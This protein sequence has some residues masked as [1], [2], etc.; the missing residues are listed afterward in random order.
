MLARCVLWPCVCP[1]VCLSVTSW[2]SI[3]MAGR[4]ELG[5]FCTESALYFLYR[6]YCVIRNS[7]FCKKDRLRLLLNSLWNLVQ[8]YEL[9]SFYRT[10]WTAESSDCAPSVCEFFLFVYEISQEP[11]NGFAPNSH[12]R[13]VWSL[14]GTSLKVRV[15]GEGHQGQKKLSRPFDR[16]PTCGLCLVKHL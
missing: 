4:I 14:A 7:G 3:E 12:G 2:S 16:R 15:K 9:A 13:R 1:S 5:F 8:N 11:L 6:A 10:R